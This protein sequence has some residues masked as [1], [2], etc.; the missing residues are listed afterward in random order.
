MLFHTKTGQDKQIATLWL[1][2]DGQMLSALKAKQPHF[3]ALRQ[4][5]LKQ[6]ARM[7]RHSH[8]R[9]WQQ[10]LAGLAEKC[11]TAPGLRKC[12]FNKG[13]SAYRGL[14]ELFNH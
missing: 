3:Q 13:N 8:T 2:S 7:Q 14:P 6:Q 4:L 10:R 9:Q 1:Q 11:L 12:I 5:W